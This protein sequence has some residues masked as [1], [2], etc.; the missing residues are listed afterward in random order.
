M[1]ATEKP[2]K[3][4][5]AIEDNFC[6]T[7]INILITGS[8]AVV[9]II[10]VR[11]I[12]VIRLVEDS[13]PGATIALSLSAFSLSLSPYIKLLL[14]DMIL[15]MRGCTTSFFY[16]QNMCFVGLKRP[17]QQNLYSNREPSPQSSC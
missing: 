3:G 15:G 13:P 4:F 1:E 17:F 10:Q 8:I 11:L 12:E 6:S 16:T 2:L 14:Y 9:L 7:K 5:S